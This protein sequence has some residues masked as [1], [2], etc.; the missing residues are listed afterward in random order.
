[1]LV[2]GLWLG[3][4]FYAAFVAGSSA[5]GF[6]QC[7]FHWLT[8]FDCPG[9]GMTRASVHVLHLEVVESFR[10]HPFGIVF[11]VGFTA[12]AMFRL[13]E[14]IAGRPLAGEFFERTKSVRQ[15]VWFSLMVLALIF[16]FGR[17]A[18]EIA[19]ILTPL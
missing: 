3:M 15:K 4:L 7:P 18:L 11:V 10:Y 16:G 2:V 6:Y 19:G 1:M 5:D 8:G 17:L 14:L 12:L 9:C 13:A